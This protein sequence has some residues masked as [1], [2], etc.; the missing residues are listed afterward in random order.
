M[1]LLFYINSYKGTDTPIK[2][3]H[4]IDP[5]LN[6]DPTTSIAHIT[7]DSDRRGAALGLDSV[8]TAGLVA[9]A[10]QLGAV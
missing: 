5:S 9:R 2:P 10:E 4:S 3:L 1:I 7:V 6:D 8:E